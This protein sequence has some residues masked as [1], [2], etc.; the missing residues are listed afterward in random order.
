[1]DEQQAWE[2]A[3]RAAFERDQLRQIYAEEDAE[4]EDSGEP[5][6]DGDPCPNCGSNR[7]MQID[8]I[9]Q[10]PTIWICEC[11]GCGMNFEIIG[12]MS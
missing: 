9:A 6:W 1:M 8:I 5:D 10:D 4:A 3:Y 7:T 12:S 11:G 2:D